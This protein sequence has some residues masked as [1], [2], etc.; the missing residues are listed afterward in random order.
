MRL[1]IPV[2]RS[3]AATRSLAPESNAI[4]LIDF[5]QLPFS[6]DRVSGGYLITI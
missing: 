5:Y 4:Q 2:S 3:I 1:Q 6:T